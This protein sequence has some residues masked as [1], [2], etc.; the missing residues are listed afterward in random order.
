M[1]DIRPHSRY[2][3]PMNVAGFIA[4]WRKVELT[5]R[6]AV[7]QHLLDLC[8]LVGHPM[9]DEAVCAAYGWSADMADEQILN[10]CWYRT[11]VQTDVE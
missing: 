2:N 7:R 4:K 5:G 11:S 6:P 8:E 10:G 1:F 9:L 3:I